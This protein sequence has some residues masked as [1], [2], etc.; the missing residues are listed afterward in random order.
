MIIK[1]VSY[2]YMSTSHTDLWWA[3]TQR[4]GRC[5]WSKHEDTHPRWKGLFGK[6]GNNLTENVQTTVWIIWTNRRQRFMFHSASTCLTNQEYQEPLGPGVWVVAY[7]PVF[8]GDCP[9][10]CTSE[11]HRHS[12]LM[13]PGTFMETHRH[14]H[15]AFNICKLA[16]DSRLNSD[17]ICLPHS[18]NV[19]LV[20]IG[21][22]L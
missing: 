10:C 5:H 19:S 22:Q 16:Q 21:G 12:D 4:L 17:C 13:C 3:W 9:C 1:Q 6:M 8:P 14:K 15:R 18:I 20:W 11:C 7:P 2:V